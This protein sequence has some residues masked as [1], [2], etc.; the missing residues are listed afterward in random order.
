MY[1]YTAYAC[2]GTLSAI[3]IT[4]KK[5]DSFLWNEFKLAH[6]NLKSNYPKI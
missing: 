3:S 4:S 6:A 5:C 1:V 2:L